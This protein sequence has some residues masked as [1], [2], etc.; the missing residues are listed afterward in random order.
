MCSLNFRKKGYL[1][2]IIN[3]GYGSFYYCRGSYSEECAQ[4]LH[5]FFLES[6]KKLL[7]HIKFKIF[8]ILHIKC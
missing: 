8:M 5:I 3:Y 7:R 4:K 1:Q 6:N 2:L